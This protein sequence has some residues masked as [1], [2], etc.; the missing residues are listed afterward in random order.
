MGE[1]HENAA[2]FKGLN[3]GFSV[4]QGFQKKWMVRGSPALG[5]TRAALGWENL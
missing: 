2:E 3:G 5:E 4:P 1:T